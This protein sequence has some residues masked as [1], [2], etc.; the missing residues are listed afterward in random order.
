MFIDR[1][2]ITLEFPEK[3]VQKAGVLDIN[4]HFNLLNVLSSRTNAK[5]FEEHV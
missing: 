4:K 1:S 5:Q 3:A 2:M